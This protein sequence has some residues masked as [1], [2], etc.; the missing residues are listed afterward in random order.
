MLQSFQHIADLS[1]ICRLGGVKK[2]VISPGSR[3]APLIDAFYSLFGESCYSI[4]D[5]RSAGY[6]ALGM[7]RYSQ[8]PVV[9]I[10]TSGT[11]VLN[12]SPAVAEAY[13]S[14]IPLLVIT[15]DR[16]GEWIDQQDNQT[17][18]QKEVYRNFI[19]KSYHLHENPENQEILRDVHH[20]IVE[21]IHVAC[22]EPKGPVHLNVPLC[23]PLYSD[24]PPV[25]KDISSAV[26]KE[27]DNTIIISDSLNTAWQ[28]AKKIL[29]VHGQDHPQS[30]IGE[31]L[32]KLSELPGV[33]VMAENISNVKA[34]SV[35]SHTDLLFSHTQQDSLES[36]DLLLYSGGQVVSRRLKNYLRGL[37]NLPAW[38]IGLD[39]YP[40]DTFK[41]HN[42]VLACQA[43][44]AYSWLD[45]IT[46]SKES[47]PDY[48]NSWLEASASAGKKRDD[49]Q[50][51]LPFS[52]VSAMKLILEAISQHSILELGNSS[53]VRLFQFFKTPENTE[54]FSNRGVSGIDGCLS[55]ASGTAASSNKLT[56]A[57]VGDLSFVYDSNALWNA[58]LSPN[59]RIVVLNNRG[60]GIFS[61][62][63]GP[64]T[65]SAYDEFF[66]AYHPVN[67]QK[68]AEAFNLNYF[69]CSDKESL[70]REL[71]RFLHPA[72]KAGVMEIK[73]KPQDNVKAF[74]MMLGKES[75]EGK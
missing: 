68:L 16:P 51:K 56:V 42:A 15:A 47:Q 36:P 38:R 67:L 54:I 1:E 37:K 4:V 45:Q 60:G 33:V 44:Q 75:P 49:L 32:I 74:R 73:T 70:T 18:R 43:L 24:L 31:V 39:D 30:E 9:L 23:E 10:C 6:F 65:K 59:L 69:C 13:Y 62:L 72:D 53:A 11:A 50:N 48:K 63:D 40:I 35:I 46:R 5:E 57:V 25:S 28:N 14:H 55:A 27:T 58:R 64:S 26:I 12:Y 61:L 29:I 20:Q 8:T 2:V 41:H 34:D 17:I 21:A 71:P 3:N 66:I 22:T 7:A 52:D 19:K